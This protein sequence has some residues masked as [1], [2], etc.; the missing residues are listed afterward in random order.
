MKRP[1]SCSAASVPAPEY[2]MPLRN[3]PI[4]WSTKPETGPLYGTRPSTP[5]GTD[6]P[7]GRAFLRV[8]IGRARLH[9]AERT[10][11]AVGFECSPLVQNRFSRRFFGSSEQSAYHRHGSP[12]RDCLRNVAGILDAAVR[13]DR[14]AGLLR[15][16]RRFEYRR[17][18][19]HARAR[20]HARSADRAGP[21]A[22]FEPVDAQRDEVAR[23][24]IRR[25]VARDELYVRQPPL[26]RADGLHHARP[27]VRAPCPPRERPP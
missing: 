15:R 12:G 25:D 2:P 19:R 10:H 7:A 14:H 22:H 9:R 17:D 1:F 27:N 13:D 16:A 20:H 11:A 3:P 21:D 5:S 24:V 6:F 23:A 8:A 26:D 18:L 4:N